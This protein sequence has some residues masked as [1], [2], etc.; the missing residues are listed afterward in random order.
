MEKYL[1]LFEEHEIEL[2][3]LMLWSEADLRDVLK[4]KS[5]VA[6]VISNALK[7]YQSPSLPSSLKFYVLFVVLLFAFQFLLM[8]LLHLR[9]VV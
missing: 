3:H 9:G 8:H 7:P 1:P 5:A 2:E 6:K 4:L